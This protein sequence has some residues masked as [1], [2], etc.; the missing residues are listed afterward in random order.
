MHIIACADSCDLTRDPSTYPFY[1]C[2][3]LYLMCRLQVRQLAAIEMRKRVSQNSGKLWTLLPQNEREEI[4][5][6]F[7]GLIVADSE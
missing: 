7:P 5:A 1:D 4:K 3:A 2:L 6:K